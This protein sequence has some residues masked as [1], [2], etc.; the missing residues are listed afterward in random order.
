MEKILISACLFGENVRYDGKNS[1]INDLD[2]QRWKNEGRLIPI[3]PEV[4]GGLPVPRIPCEI[5]AQSG[6]VLSERGEDFT[7]AFLAGAQRALELAKTHGVR[8]ALLKERSPSCGSHEI[9]DGSFTGQKIIGAGLTSRLLQEH[10]IEVF[11]E[12]NL[13]EL[14]L[15]LQTR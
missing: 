1:L 7:S 15:R 14:K 2:F 4:A 13:N 10:H 3:C 6:L 8:F 5:N 9:Y 12:E 11:S